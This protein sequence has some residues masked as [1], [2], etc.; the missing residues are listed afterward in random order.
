MRNYLLCGAAG[1]VG[2]QILQTIKEFAPDDIFYAADIAVDKIAEY[3][4]DYI[5]VITNDEIEA[6]LSHNHIDALLLLAFPRNV[7]PRQWAPGIDYSF[8]IVSL[9]KKYGVG[10]FIHVSSQSLYGYDRKEP[11]NEGSVV[12]LTSPYTTGKYCIEKLLESTFEAG[13]FTSVRLSTIIGPRTA[14]RVVNKFLNQI[15]SGKDISI[16]GGEQIFS[17]L[18]VRDA[19]IGLCTILV[20]DKKD[21]KP[22][23]NVGTSESIKIL[24]LANMCEDIVS[25]KG[26]PPKTAV[27]FTKDDSAILNNQIDVSLVKADFGWEAKYSLKESVE[28]IFKAISVISTLK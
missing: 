13:T 27:T 19:A 21:M 17:F 8:R 25:K 20:S 4:S 15:L 14:E 28:T 24:D 1:M 12:A 9:A 7:Q 11:A 5:R 22:V 3:D 18:D 23:Y 6:V 26:A 16:K 2:S 10:R